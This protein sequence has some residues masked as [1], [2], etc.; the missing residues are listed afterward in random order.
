MRARC[1]LALLLVGGRCA[2]EPAAP[3][4]LLGAFT[5]HFVSPDGRV[6]DRT[7]GDVTTS[8]GQSYALFFALV[9]G[10][11]PLFD[12]LLR[13]TEDNLAGGDLG[14]RLPATRWGRRGDGRWGV[15]DPHSAAD[16]D[17]WI[18][19]DL[20]EAGRLWGEPR[21]DRLGRRVRAQVVAREVAHLPGLGPMLLPGPVGFVL[22]GDTW[23]L[24]PSYLP[25]QLLAGLAAERVPGPWA[26]IRSGARRMLEARAAHG[27]V[28]DWV[29]FRRRHGFVVDPVAGPTGSYDAIRVY[30]W[31]SLLADDD[32]DKAA[33]LGRL[34]GP[35]RSWLRLG[36]VPERVD[37]R[38]P[39][40]PARPGPPGFLAVLLPRARTDDAEAWRRLRRQLDEHRRGGLYG[41]PPAYYDHALLL[42]AQG[43]DERRF[44]FAADGRLG[45]PWRALSK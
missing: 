26:A 29:A 12:R 24:N 34:D 20:V 3:W 4:P 18:G 15:L 7:G 40:Q 5:A 35:W 45:V 10:D 23:R 30:L 1:A 13:W 39:E 2:A 16:S 25:P 6:V 37:P 43:F 44:A 42:F 33:L 14:A 32:P 11:R 17:L 41:D 9:A 36:E 19:Y 8:E 31:P 22:D 27:F 21:L 28:A 38:R